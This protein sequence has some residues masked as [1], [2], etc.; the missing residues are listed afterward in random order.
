MSSPHL[1]SEILDLI[2]DHLHDTR[3]A[4][5]NCCLVAKSWLQRTRK[6]LFANVDFP[7]VET[8]QSW[9]ET[10]PDPSTSPARYAKTLSVGCLEVVTAA[11]ADVGG[12][13]RGF[14]RVEHLDIRVDT[15]NFDDPAAALV[16]FH[17]L[18]PVIKSLRVDILALPHSPIINLISSFPLLEDLAVTIHYG[19][20]D[21]TG[22]GPEGDETLTAA[23]PLTPPMFTGSLE[24][25][26][27]EGAKAFVRRLLSLPGGIHFRKLAMTCLRGR[28]L[29]LTTGLVEACSRTLESLDITFHLLGMSNRHL[30]WHR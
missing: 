10:F 23:Q 17:G 19:R 18:S 26:L 7:F 9:K 15:F 3:R 4:L 21:E 8:L 13:I 29:L 16:P 14:S 27:K 5:R 1:P 28:D 20:W 30:H 22:D 12:W 25:H 2:V 24:L 6:H 11:D